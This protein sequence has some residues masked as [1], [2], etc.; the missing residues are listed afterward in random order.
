MRNYWLSR[1]DF[2]LGT[3][4]MIFRYVFARHTG[5]VVGHQPD[6]G[7]EIHLTSISFNGEPLYTILGP[8]EVQKM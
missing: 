1:L 4:V 3:V 7:L 5:T 6:G 2:P 8:H